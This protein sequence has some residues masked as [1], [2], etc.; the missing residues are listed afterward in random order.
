MEVREDYPHTLLA[1]D[2]TDAE[3]EKYWNKYKYDIPVLHLNDQYWIKHR[4]STE[5]AIHG[6][7]S[8]A[9]GKFVSPAGEPN[10]AAT[11]R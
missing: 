3:H 6:L 2:I 8:F 11:E 1:V 10:A 5:E 7:K 9:E 4:L